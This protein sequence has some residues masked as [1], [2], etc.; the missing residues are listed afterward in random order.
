MIKVIHIVGARPQFM[1]LS[2][3]YNEMKKNNFNQKIIHTGQHYDD[4][5]SKV[6][7]EQLGIPSPDFNLNI[8][9]LPHGA[10]TGRMI[11]DIEKILITSSFDYVIVYGDTNS[12]FAGALTGKKM[13]LKIVH[14]ESGVRNDDMNMPEEINRVLSDR[15]SDIL[16]C[17]SDRSIKNLVSEGYKNFDCIIQNSGDLMY[18][19]FL[20]FKNKIIKPSNSEYVLVTC[21][22]ESNTSENNLKEIIKALNHLSKEH[23]IIFP[24]HPR[25]KAKMD[26]LDIKLE[27]DSINPVDYFN[28]IGLLK[29]CKYLITD[30]GGAVR[31]SYW[32]NKPSLLLLEKPLWP[33]LVEA[34]VCLNTIPKFDQIISQFSSLKNI[35]DKFPKGIFGDGKASSIIT[36]NLM[37]HYAGGL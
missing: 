2:P 7:F 8:N 36:E 22:R 26:S 32:L 30:S 1:K 12:T 25:T 4:I 27:F 24:I 20:N 31:E 21:H 19:C 6:F 18:D 15:I 13:G 35:N 5:M 9:N 16:F 11:E 28:F 34:G 29:N 33:E 10:M 14:I 17:N 23:E 37:K 3:L